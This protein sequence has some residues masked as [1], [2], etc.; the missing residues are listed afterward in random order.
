MAA[1]D[2]LFDT[3]L[4]SERLHQ[5]VLGP[6]LTR[7]RLLEKLGIPGTPSQDDWDWEPERGLFDLAI[8]LSAEDESTRRVWIELK[9]DSDLDSKQLNRQLDFVEGTR[10]HIL[11]LLLGTA[12]HS[13]GDWR[14]HSI[15]E[16]RKADDAYGLVRSANELDGHLRDLA[17]DFD[18]NA[19]ARD[20]RDL[21]ITYRAALARLDQ[22]MAR[23]GERPLD[24]WQH[25]DF[26]GF[27]AELRKRNPSTHGQMWIGKVNTPQGAFTAAAWGWTKTL[28]IYGLREVHLQWQGNHKPAA[29][30]KLCIKINVPDP[31]NQRRLRSKMHKIVRDT[32]QHLG[33]DVRKPSR[34]GT[35]E[36]MTVAILDQRPLAAAEDWATRWRLIGQAVSDAETILEHLAQLAPAE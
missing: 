34:F 25:T 35:G 20:L 36:T 5:I 28:D 17:A 3:K 15:E 27:F 33:I 31:A 8:T 2:L 29:D 12:A 24:E 22:R 30:L 18:T 16:R 13:G 21:M 19:N 7:S 10:D 4:E 23:F 6:I 26:M 32:A 1:I 14:V 9:I 11:Y